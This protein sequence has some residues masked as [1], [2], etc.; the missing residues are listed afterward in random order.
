[1]SSWLVTSAVTAGAVQAGKY[2]RLRYL[3]DAIVRAC[4]LLDLALA[5]LILAEGSSLHA[6]TAQS[7]FPP[8]DLMLE[9]VTAAPRPQLHT[10]ISRG[11][12]RMQHV[13]DEFVAR[14][15]WSHVRPPRRLRRRYEP[16]DLTSAG[17]RNVVADELAN[18][19]LML[20]DG[21]IDTDDIE[22][23]VARGQYGPATW[24]AGPVLRELAELRAW[25]HAV[26]ATNPQSG[27]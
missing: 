8:A 25:L 26:A 21:S 14:G 4:L 19:L 18:V 15:W 23:E 20:F 3:S 5:R 6:A 11:P 16:T 27:G 13:I 10:S 24:L 17:V 12:V 9:A 1:M 2:P 7:G 22:A